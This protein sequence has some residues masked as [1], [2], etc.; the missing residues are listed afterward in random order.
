MPKAINESTSTKANGGGSTSA[1]KK[2]PPKSSTSSKQAPKKA[3][4][5]KAKA[6][7]KTA[8]AKR[9][10]PAKKRLSTKAA[11]KVHG[12]RTK[13]R[14]APRRGAGVQGPST[15]KKLQQKKK[16]QSKSQ[17]TSI[18]VMKERMPRESIPLQF[19]EALITL[20][21]ETEGPGLKLLNTAAVKK[22]KDTHKG[23][24]GLNLKDWPFS[25]RTVI[26]EE[27]E[28]YF[29]IKMLYAFLYNTHYLF[30][31]CCYWLIWLGIFYLLRPYSPPRLNLLRA[32]FLI[33]IVPFSPPR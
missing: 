20:P 3:A 22:L 25:G 11:G 9:K 18:E 29:N 32:I 17:P 21:K 28:Y 19:D 14:G 13:H 7:N 10:D 24:K 8:S 33:C 4:S 26:E 30:Y 2:A 23:V 31:Y 5:T 1:T 16:N 6:N 15:K 12:G 27:C